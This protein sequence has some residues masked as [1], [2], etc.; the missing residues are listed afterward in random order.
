MSRENR[1]LK[2][3]GFLV[4]MDVRFHADVDAKKS[5]L[6]V[7]STPIDSVSGGFPP[8]VR[9]ARGIPLI[10]LHQILWTAV[11]AL[12]YASSFT[13]PAAGQFET[14]SFTPVFNGPFSVAV[15]D[16]NRDGKQDVVV[17]NRNGPVGIAVLLGNGDGTLLPAV[18]YS[19]GQFPIGVAT[20]D[21]NHDGILDLLVASDGLYVLLG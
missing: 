21:L 14:R 5:D 16:F 7:R 19:A 17:A 6:V 1:N 18:N 2:I 20:A 12:A 3:P 11:L 4:N 10:R 15:G 8:F 9:S 13:L